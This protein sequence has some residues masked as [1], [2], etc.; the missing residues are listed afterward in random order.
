MSNLGMTSDQIL[1][2]AQN[3][4]VSGGYNGFSYADIAEVVG[5][6]KASIHHHF[7][8]KVDLVRTL[9]ERH[10]ER[11]EAGMADLESKVP[12]PVA[13]LQ[14]YAGHW[15]RCI[16]DASIPFCV[17][18]LLASELPALPPEVAVEVRAYFRFLSSWL[19]KV[20][21]RGAEQGVLKFTG[22]AELEAETFMA[23][24]HGAML[25]ARAYGNPALFDAILTPT[26]QRL[27]AKVH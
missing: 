20:M 10:R 25:S 21:E 6:R 1:A 12:D 3:F 19:T 14:T 13:L 15:A 8:S 24:I 4:I 11:A 7:P 27:A 9:V 2:S 23:T 5:I 16:E 17:C 26:V 22:S 18:A